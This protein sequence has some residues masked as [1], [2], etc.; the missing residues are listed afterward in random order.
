MDEINE[1]TVNTE[2]DGSESFSRNGD[3]AGSF[4]GR[5]DIP[6]SIKREGISISMEKHADVLVYKRETPYE[7]MERVLL[8]DNAQILINPVEP[9]NTPK[10]ITPFLHIEFE[11]VLV[12]EPKVSKVVCI[13]FPIEIG[14]FISGSKDLESLDIFSLEKQKFTL[15]GDPSNGIICR[16][17]G[18]DVHPVI[19]PLNPL[20][21]GVLSL[22]IINTTGKWLQVSQAVFN[23]YG[24]KIYYNK[25]V[26]SMKA[27]M[28]IMSNRTAETDFMDSP[29]IAEMENSLELYTVRKLV[30]TSTKYV[31]EAGI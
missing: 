29:I 1:D 31:M 19:P 2:Q 27:S 21:S 11:K 17:W 26:V 13:T 4:F 12:L 28:R 10:E 7:T 8:A 22:K 25:D 20:H 5:Y 23:A 14:V 15:Y 30:V 6:L 9:L 16:S 3:L 24:M 18:S